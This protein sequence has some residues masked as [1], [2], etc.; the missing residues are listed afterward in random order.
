MRRAH[1]TRVKYVIDRCRC[2]ECRV[3]NAN[4][5]WARIQAKRR[6]EWAPYASAREVREAL[7]H[8]ARLRSVGMGARSIALAAGLKRK[9]VV[10]LLRPDV[11]PRRGRPARRRP[12][13]ETIE[14]ILAVRVSE[15]RPDHVISAD[16]TWRLIH[17]MRRA[18][19]PKARIARALGYKRFAL[20]FN[21]RQ[22]KVR[23]A[24]KVRDLHHLWLS[25]RLESAQQRLDRALQEVM[26][27]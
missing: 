17:E 19:I 14:R 13:R 11:R 16:E 6:G 22:V 9:T 5:E 10:E 12:R 26:L 3:A 1:G 7:V 21:A 4:Y 15:L 8:I 2:F 25:R 18:G 27:T 24:L 20:Q 23:N